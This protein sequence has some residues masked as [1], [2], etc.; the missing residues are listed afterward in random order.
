VRRGRCAR[1][2]A[3]ALGAV[4]ESA[5]IVHPGREWADQSRRSGSTAPA[6]RA[7]DTQLQRTVA[8]KILRRESAAHLL[9]EA[10]TASALSHPNIC[11]VFDI[12]LAADPP[13]IVMEHVEGHVTSI[14]SALAVAVSGGSGRS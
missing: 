11:A 10:R 14:R 12:Q 8:I 4:N 3:L 9:H 7:R 5:F 6:R 2:A 1:G 13:F